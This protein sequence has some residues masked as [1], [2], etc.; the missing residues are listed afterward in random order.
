MPVTA[1]QL[2]RACAVIG[3]E[4]NDGIPSLAHR[5]NLAQDLTDFGIHAGCHGRVNGRLG[6]L[7]IFL[8]LGE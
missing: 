8:L 4:D 5:L 6:A 1:N 3:K 7:E 2:L